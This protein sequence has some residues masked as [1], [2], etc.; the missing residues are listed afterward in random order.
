MKTMN[1]STSYMG[2]RLKNPL[3]VASSKLTSN[4]ENVKKCIDQGAGAIVLKSLFEEQLLTDSDKLI[5]KDAKYFWYPEAIDYINTYSKA[6]GIREHLDLIKEIKAYCDTPV[7]VSVNCVTSKEW[8]EFAKHFEEAGADGIE[9]NIAISP[10][11]P[12]TESVEIEDAYVEIVREVKKN[13]SIPISV[14]I[15]PFFTNMSRITNRLVKAGADGIVLFNR[16]FRP[17]IDIDSQNVVE[18][19][20]LSSPQ[21]ITQSLRWISIL[22]P[23]L[24]CDIAASTGVHDFK[25]FVKQLLAGAES[26]QLCSALYNKGLGYIDTLLFDLAKWMEKNDFKTIDDFKGKVAN[27]STNTPAFQRVQYMKRN[28]D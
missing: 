4:F 13:V 24:N 9:L 15:G 18:D 17:D 22:S 8:P 21:E 12:S 6:Y 10:F 28:F 25:G 1:L 19:N 2:I 23:K 27:D 26:V 20:F 3:I 5:E 14:K 11:D 16:F 7:I